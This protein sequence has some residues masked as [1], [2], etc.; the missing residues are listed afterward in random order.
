M[1]QLYTLSPSPYLT[2]LDADG[3][4]VSGALIYTYLS[5]LVTETTTY[6]DAAGTTENANPIEADSAGRFVAYLPPGVSQGWVIKTPAGVTIR[7]IDPITSVPLSATNQDVTGTFAVNVTAG[8]AVYLSD[9][10]GGNN[11]GQWYLADA[12]NTYSSTLP[13]VGMAVDDVTGG[14][15]PGGQGTIR[16]GGT[17]TG[18]TA[19]TVGTS[20]YISGTAG[21]IRSTPPDNARFMGVAIATDTL[22]LVANPPVPVG[23]TVLETQ[24]FGG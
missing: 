7:T 3:E 16:L 2:I 22:V 13:I 18:L 10:S 24:V 12:D 11:A 9:G 4:P 23:L 21:S 17:V 14:F 6:A 5:G 8:Q 1:S 20:Y 19:L 15:A